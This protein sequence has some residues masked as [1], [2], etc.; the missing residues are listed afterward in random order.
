MAARTAS[1][2][3]LKALLEAI[4]QKDAQICMFVT[5]NL[6]LCL[7]VTKWLFERLRKDIGDEA[8]KSLLEERF[9]VWFVVCGC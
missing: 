4:L 7:Q 5:R 8:A 3:G 9:R 6:A 1:R 2:F